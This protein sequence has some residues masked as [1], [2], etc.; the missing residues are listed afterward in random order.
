MPQGLYPGGYLVGKT[1]VPIYFLVLLLVLSIG[2]EALGSSQVCVGT[3]SSSTTETHKNTNQLSLIPIHH[4]TSTKPQNSVLTLLNMAG[5]L[6]QHREAGA[7]IEK[8]GEF[9]LGRN[10][11]KGYSL[12]LTYLLD[13][14]APSPVFRLSKIKLVNP[15]GQTQDLSKEPLDTKGRTLVQTSFDLPLEIG[16]KDIELPVV[17]QGE[18]LTEFLK[19]RDRFEFLEANELRNLKSVDD[20]KALYF[21]YLKRSQ[22][23]L[24]V[25]RAQ[26]E[27]SK[28]VF[29]LALIMGINQV[30]GLL[31]QS[32]ENPG[33]KPTEITLPSVQNNLAQAILKNMTGTR[34]SG[35]EASLRLSD[36]LRSKQQFQLVTILDSQAAIPTVYTVYYFEAQR[37]FLVIEQNMSAQSITGLVV[38]NS[39]A[40]NY[41]L[42]LEIFR[43]QNGNSIQ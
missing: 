11:G 38:T 8:H 3:L 37:Q 25:G 30:P 17:I 29:T 21:S 33:V 40:S 2:A 42:L 1:I 15:N 32:P 31:K 7:N 43:N 35:G 28:I 27:Y 22:K 41:Q 9:N 39:E 12:E 36:A 26:K 14:R 24:F 34:L 5:E 18:V 16:K 10:L 13:E 23:D 4:S 6:R 19:W 20:F